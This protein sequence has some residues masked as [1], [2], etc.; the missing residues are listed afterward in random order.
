M[1]LL[2]RPEVNITDFRLHRNQGHYDGIEKPSHVIPLFMG[3]EAGKD[4]S[5]S[6]FC[7]QTVLSQDKGTLIGM[8]VKC[9]CLFMCFLC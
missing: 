5:C 2:N 8:L 9:S 4:H 6:H 7:D 3:F 1:T